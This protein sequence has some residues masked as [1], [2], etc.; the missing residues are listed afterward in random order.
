MNT[1]WIH[2]D[3]MQRCRKVSDSCYE[4]IEANEVDDMFLISDP[5]TID[6]RDWVRDGE[7]TNE[8][9]SIIRSYYSD[10]KDWIRIPKEDR[11][12]YLAE[13]IYESTS[14]LNCKSELYTG[15]QANEIL[16]RYC[17]T[18]ILV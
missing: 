4:L 13:M 9:K 2:T 10:W 16:D 18:G 14:H 12:Q 17:K 6:L 1:E 11:S 5:M 15:E 7:Y 8:A 3:D